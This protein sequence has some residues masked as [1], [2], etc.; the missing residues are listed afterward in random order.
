MRYLKVIERMSTTVKSKKRKLDDPTQIGECLMIKSLER[1]SQ[2]NS[3][4]SSICKRLF[5]LGPDRIHI[6]V[7]SDNFNGYLKN[8]LEYSWSGTYSYL[9][10]IN[11][12]KAYKAS[13]MST[14]FF[15]NEFENF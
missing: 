12:R 10:I 6:K 9:E 3:H 2:F 15:P 13:L 8:S 7:V 11:E 14:K 1:N 4:Y 5:I